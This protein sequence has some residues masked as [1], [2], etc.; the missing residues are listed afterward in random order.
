MIAK[1]VATSHVVSSLSIWILSVRRCRAEET[2][3][4]AHSVWQIFVQNFGRLQQL[5][6]AEIVRILEHQKVVQV[7]NSDANDLVETAT[8]EKDSIR[9]EVEKIH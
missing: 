5:S 8:K 9:L 1:S 2:A 7:A 4:A 6:S 3:H